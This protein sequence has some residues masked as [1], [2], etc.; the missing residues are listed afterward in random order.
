MR[1]RVSVFV[2]ASH[3]PSREV[4]VMG[5]TKRSTMV[6]ALL[7][8]LFA[9]PAYAQQTGTI[10]GRITASET[11]RPVAQA[12]VLARRDSRTVAG[13]VTNQLGVY[14]L[15][16]VPAG[17]YTIVVEAL[18]HGSQAIGMAQVTG[19]G[20]ATVDGELET[21]ALVLDPVVVTTSRGQQVKA[22][23]SPA[24]T[25][26]IGEAA[27]E[28]RPTVTAADYLQSNAAVDIIRQGVQS[29]NVVVRGFN[30]I[31]SGA[32]HMLT[33]NRI[34]GVPSLRVNVLNFIPS[35]NDD[36]ER[37]EVV[38]GPGSA[39]YGPNTANGVIH[40][41]TKSPLS[42]SGTTVSVAGGEQSA[43]QA[44]FRTSHLLSD[45]VGFKL[46]GQY[47]QAEEWSYTDPVEAAEA[48]KFAN[49]P[50]GF[51]RNDLIN[52]TGIPAAEADLRISRI[53]DRDPDMKRWSGEA[54]MDWR[55]SDDALA[56]FSVG[57]SDASQIELTGLG[58]GQ[59]ENWTYN[60]VQARAT[61][62]R[63]FAQAYLN[64][65]DAGDTY[66]IRNGARI[67]DK[68]KLWVGQLQNQT[69]IGARQNFTYG[70][71]LIKTLPETEGTINGIYEDDDE[72]TEV[73][74]YLQSQTAVS[75]KI[76]LVLA[77]RIDDH[78]AL[79]DPIFSPRAAIVLK[80]AVGHNFRFTYNR[81]F[82]TPTSLNRYLDLPT[83]VPNPDLARLG[84]SVRVQGTGGEG[85]TFRQA[86][87]GYL[88]RTPQLLGG[89]ASLIPADVTPFWRSAVETVA[90]GA[91]EMGQPIDPMLLG[92][93]RTLTP[94]AAQISTNYLNTTNLAT[95]SLADLDLPTIE[96][97]REETST[98]FEAGYQGL[99]A[100]GRLALA[101]D[102]WYSKRENLVTPLTTQTPLLLLNGQET[103]AFLVA[104]LIQ[105]L[106]MPAAQAQAV[107]GQLTPFLA[108]VPLGVIS[109]PDINANGAQLLATYVNVDKSI[110]LWG[111][112][113]SARA[114]LNDRWSTT[115]SA[116][117]VND[118]KF[119]YVLGSD[120]TDVTLNAPKFKAAGSLAYDHAG[121]TG[122]SAEARLR[123]NDQF[124]ALSGVYQGSRC[125]FEG[126]VPVAVD[127]E[128]CVDSSTIVDLLLNYDLPFQPGMSI[129]LSVQNVFDESYRSFPGVPNIGR[130]AMLRLRYAFGGN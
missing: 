119:E 12:L 63:F 106:G 9:G 61:W 100:G 53:G 130:F 99:L 88:M 109:S 41:I 55:V 57:R 59:A 54:R 81:A 45:N 13:G 42:S 38:Y 34:A 66:L 26:V 37:I 97:I 35:N 126:A 110:D 10:T 108:Q 112:D 25:E 96:A 89:P 2:A 19:G 107:A 94:T 128:D 121:P 118:D 7:A 51:W 75:P 15:T 36:L 98:T 71:D 120:T 48:E 58:A 91:A 18:G 28:A 76:D 102:V 105:D 101:G 64:A 95:G 1:G 123:Y 69:S 4:P 127:I 82:S 30:N 6:A 29:T 21:R 17:S 68:S 87:G 103:G 27:I 22:S 11:T 80:P 115:V 24:H 32:T 5:A 113:L 60:F 116:S 70:I 111:V 56:I 3:I 23:E 86:N 39:L 14:R 129:D 49:D 72:T 46:S 79:P 44:M 47:F 125:L 104:R 78:S 74:A 52:A 8:T 92:Y 33:D 90:L 62:K 40:M 65:S 77:G 83:A 67:V 20:T 16:G 114:L 43:L 73:G 93:L 50:T 31:F 117:F 124:P 85:F 84:Y 122:F